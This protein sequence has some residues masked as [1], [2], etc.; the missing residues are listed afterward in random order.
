MTPAILLAAAL[1]AATAPAARA[2]DVCYDSAIVG[3]IVTAKHY[4]D[5]EQFIAPTSAAS[6]MLGGRWDVDIAVDRVLAGA[7]MPATV[8]ARVVLTDLLSPKARLLLLMRKGPV[9]PGRDNTVQD[10]GWGFVPAASAA[11]P[12]RVVFLK[13][14][15]DGVDASDPALPPRCS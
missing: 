8:R 7:R 15:R 4:A 13:S 6:I 5:L 2:A 9:E 12:W 11:I 10:L 3:R 14:W 1:A